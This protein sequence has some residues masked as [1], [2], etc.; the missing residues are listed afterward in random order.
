MDPEKT[1]ERVKEAKT[2][3]V[4]R[5]KETQVTM[6]LHPDEGYRISNERGETIA[7]ENS[8]SEADDTFRKVVELYSQ[9]G[10]ESEAAFSEVWSTDGETT[11]GTVNVNATIS[12]ECHGSVDV[13]RALGDAEVRDAV[14]DALKD[15]IDDE[16]DLKGY[17]VESWESKVIHRFK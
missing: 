9:P 16:E 14:E 7:I 1:E 3:V 5:D 8:R 13:T 17:E 12:L 2:E 6:T 4:D 15:V 11:T 10:V